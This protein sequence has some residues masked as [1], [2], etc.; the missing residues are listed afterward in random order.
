MLAE[1]SACFD[2]LSDYT[3]DTGEIS[4]DEGAERIARSYLDYLGQR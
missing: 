3:I 4:V 2:G 1:R